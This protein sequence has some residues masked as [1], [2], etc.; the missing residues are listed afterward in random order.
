MKLKKNIYIHLEILAKELSSHLLLSVIALKKN[1]RIYIGDA[2]SLEKLLIK[3]NKK[4]GIF[5]AKGNIN[6][7]MHNLVKKKCEKLVALDQEISPGFSSKYYNYII[8]M[9]Y[10]RS[11]DNFDLFFV[12][13]NKIKR[14]F[15]NT[16]P[17]NKDKVISTGWPRIDLLSNEFLPIYSKKI[18]NVKKKYGKFF[19]FNSDFGF[20]T[21]I[22]REN[23][24]K[25][26]KKSINNQN[27]INNIAPN[28][29]IDDFENFKKFLKQLKKLKKLPKIVFR[30]HPA[31]NLLEWEKI[32]KID[33]RFI[34]DN[35][36]NDVA[37]MI[38]ASEG[39]LH[40]GCTTAYQS[41]LAKKKTGYINLTNRF[42]NFSDFRPSIYKYSD[43]IKN[44]N[45]LK[46]WFGIKSKKKNLK[47][48]YSEL[49]INKKISAENIV[50]EL[51]KL[52]ISL[53]NNN[54]KFKLYND[55][56]LQF[57]KYKSIIY[58]FLISLKILKQRNYYKLNAQLKI[59][60]EF[61]KNF[62]KNQ[63]KIISKA[64]FLKKKITVS[65]ITD[66]LFEIDT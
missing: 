14:S 61:N 64:L 33:S 46:K 43:K 58:D 31:E 42:K 56:E 3:K 17:I 25:F 49:N 47:E 11:T 28:Y 52:N 10:A 39:V 16:F 50:D 19:L 4:E 27:I 22:D 35:P 36:K 21:K 34:I 38:H 26:V 1:Y 2:Y 7:S 66:N 40:R 53:Q 6:N 51:E 44:I 23:M 37:E 55:L 65:K 48:L 63:I 5:L 57:R 18:S 12:C 13:N 54:Y 9:R 45:D 20:L 32:K 59:G 29:K 60:R 15:L 41:I 8:K 24:V 30:P 62:L